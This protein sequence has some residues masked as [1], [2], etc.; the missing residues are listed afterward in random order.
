M[1]SRVVKSWWSCRNSSSRP[2]S[3]AS[4]PEFADD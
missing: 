1:L 3:S 4:D 2:V